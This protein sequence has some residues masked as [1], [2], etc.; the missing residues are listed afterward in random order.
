MNQNNNYKT[1]I[2]FLLLS[3]ISLEMSFNAFF[4]PFCGIKTIV[5][6][7]VATPTT[8]IFVG[9]IGILFERTRRLTSLSYRPGRGKG[10]GARVGDEWN[11]VT[12]QNWAKHVPPSP[13][14]P[15]KRWGWRPRSGK[16]C[17]RPVH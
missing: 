8:R 10:E 13:L 11:Y 16:A 15:L 17:F 5:S 2:M 9:L 1:T 6:Y 3:K 14:M 7:S 4:Y 12:R